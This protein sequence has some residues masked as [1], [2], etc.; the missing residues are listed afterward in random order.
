MENNPSFA[1]SFIIG[2]L[3]GILMPII[4]FVLYYIIRFE[5]VEFGDYIKWLIESEK[6][7]NVMSLSVAPNLI[8]F[9]FFV[10]RDKLK[11]GRG[12]LFATILFG[13]LIFVIKWS[14]G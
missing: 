11:S 3:V 1:N 4:V 7:I 9:M 12:V 6:I 14:V 13:V 10:K 5:E 8:S 2:T